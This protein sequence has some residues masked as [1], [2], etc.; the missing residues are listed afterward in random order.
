MREGRG[1]LICS[2]S[3]FPL[4]FQLTPA[5]VVVEVISS[6][7]RL[8][9]PARADTALRVPDLRAVALPAFLL[10]VDVV[11]DAHAVVRLVMLFV[12]AML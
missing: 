4:V 8:D 2:S 9:V 3:G 6:A 12:V 11:A 1:A 5:C 10:L 7:A